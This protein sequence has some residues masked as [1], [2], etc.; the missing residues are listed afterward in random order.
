MNSDMLKYTMM[1]GADSDIQVLNI[2][3]SNEILFKF[4]ES[5]CNYF[6]KLNIN[7]NKDLI[8]VINFIWESLR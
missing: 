6:F 2:F 8:A 1:L 4:R 3:D 7:H 5:Y